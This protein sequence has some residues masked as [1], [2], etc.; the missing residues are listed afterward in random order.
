LALLAKRLG[1]SD[2][3]PMLQRVARDATDLLA[4]GRALHALD[5][6]DE[7]NNVFR[8]AVAKAPKDPELNTAWGEL[9]LDAHQ[10][11]DALEL[12]Q[13]ALEGDE[14][15]TPAFLGAARA[16]SDDDPPQAMGAAR[17]ALEINPSYVEAQVFLAHQAIDQD[18]KDEARELL[19]K[20]LSVNP[21]S[22]D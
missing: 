14:R 1:R 6:F 5:E 4:T 16:L 21:S 2:A 18:R 20:A 3:T 12:F 8:N 7:A 10:N 11:A 15:W 17:K 13:T 22:L 19:A 9:Y